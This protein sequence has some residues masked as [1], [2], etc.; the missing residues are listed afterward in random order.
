M[1][2]L[3]FSLLCVVLLLNLGC[4]GSSQDV[5]PGDLAEYIRANYTKREVRIPMRD[6]VT[7]FAAVYTPADASPSHTYPI[8]MT[9][10]PYSSGPY[11][12]DAFPEKLGPSVEFAA[13]RYIF[14]STDVRGR[15]MSEGEFVNM[16]PVIENKEPDDIDE[17]TDTW[18][19]VEWLVQNVA[20]NN[21]KVGIWGNSYPGFYTATG[22]IDTHPAIKAAMPSAPI[23]DWYFDDMHHHGAFSLNLAFSFFSSFGVEREGLVTEWPK[24]FDFGTPDGYRFFLDLGPLSN[25][26]REHFH[27]EVPFW[28]AIVAHPDYDEFWASRSTLTHLQNITCAVMV[29]GGLF[30]AEDLYGIFHTYAAIEALNPEISNTFV[31]GPWSHGAW[32]RR[33]GR[34]LGGA[35][36]GFATAE[37]FRE[38]LLLPFFAHFLKGADAPE[39]PEALVF[40]TGINRWRPF[41]QWPPADLA[42]EPLYLGA[43][44][45]LSWEPP[46]RSDDPY[47]EFISDPAKPV[48]YTAAI[49]TRWHAEYMTEDQ[50]FAS[51]RPDVLVYRS[52]PLAE[53]L[54]IAGPMQVQLQVSTTGS[55]ADWMVKLID[56]FPG[57]LPGFDKD[58]DEEDLGHTERLIRSEMFRGRYREGYGDPVPFEPGKVTR[59]DFPLQGVLHTFKKGHRIVIQVQSSLFP[60]F[61]R[62]PQT[63]VPNIFRAKEDDYVAA[64][65][66]IYHTP[67][68]PSAIWV[69]LPGRPDTR[70]GELDR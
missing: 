27:G 8:L 46:T 68:R 43:G 41:G 63:F 44:G 4:G 19:T 5:D 65:H 51:R 17:T 20:N 1:R 33:D 31:L 24:R 32:L 69:G 26:N 50:R 40:E 37:D 35:D 11:G 62:N 36:F 66:R 12:E 45:S 53:N 23:A 28:S 6:G 59:V 10:T 15:F 39:M 22:I 21:G 48:P 42:M 57:R 67:D 61:D 54:T 18:D 25:V 30:D 56:E 55:D 29:V 14:V 49:T 9:R 3:F 60:F 13:E 7:L 58:S 2:R 38:R 70:S 52:E 47:D 64:T 16:R 34:S